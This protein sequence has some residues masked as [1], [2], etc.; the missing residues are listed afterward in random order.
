MIER[1]FRTR[2]ALFA[3]V[4]VMALFAACGDKKGNTVYGHGPQVNTETIDYTVSGN[5]L[6]LQPPQEYS[7][8]SYCDGD[9]LVTQIDTQQAETMPIELSGS[10]LALVINEQSLDTSNAVVEYLI[11]LSRNDA[12]SG[13]VGTWTYSS[14]S[15][16]VV[17]GTPTPGEIAQI[18]V[19]VTG[20]TAYLS[21][22]QMTFS[23][24]QVTISEVINSTFAQDFIDNWNG[25]GAYSDSAMY[26][27]TVKQL[28][29]AS[30][31]LDG[32]N[33]EKVTVSEDADYNDTYTSTVAAHTAYTYFSNPTKCPDDNEPTWYQDFLDANQKTAA[34]AKRVIR[35][36]A[37]KKRVRGIF[38]IP[39]TIH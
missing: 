20:M 2:D 23:S 4:V 21:S 25:N 6:I 14:C 3:G 26:A 35:K 22:M 15:Y 7:S 13:L 9:S 33:G 29:A 16:R 36:P 8:Y 39:N 30:V 10:T 28:S 34:L 32:R 17:S 11:N 38:G 12:G 31:E 24:S 5:D 27:I 19:D 1:R 37:E 18:N